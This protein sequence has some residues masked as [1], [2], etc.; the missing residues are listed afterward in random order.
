MYLNVELTIE[1][2]RECELISR[3]SVMKNERASVSL[4]GVKFD[5]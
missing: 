4:E 5:N 2:T 3:E 1:G